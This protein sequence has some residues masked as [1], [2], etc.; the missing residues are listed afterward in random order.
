[1][2]RAGPNSRGK[3]MKNKL[4]VLIAAALLASC[5][6]QPDGP[7]SDGV[8]DTTADG[9]STAATLHAYKQDIA[10]RISQVNS[11]HVYAER[12]QALLRSIVVLKFAVDENGRLLRSEIQ[13]S[14]RDRHAE[15]TA[16]DSLKRTAPF[17]KPAQHLLRHGKLEMSESWLFN[18]DGR[19]QLRS[20]ALPQMDR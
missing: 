12:P 13:R 16:L 8:V 2:H 14:N 7:K 11:R 4:A 6:T 10:Q 5:S 15:S 17:P 18:N 1:M 3:I 9:T 19:F 20:V